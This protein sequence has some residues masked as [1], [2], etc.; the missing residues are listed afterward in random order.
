[1]STSSPILGKKRSFGDLEDDGGDIFGSKKV[2][3]RSRNCNV[4]AYKMVQHKVKWIVGRCNLM[5]KGSNIGQDGR[6][7]S[8]SLMMEGCKKDL[9]EDCKSKS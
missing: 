9:N 1:M 5:Y 2:M 3:R 6:A 7:L 8:M 4:D